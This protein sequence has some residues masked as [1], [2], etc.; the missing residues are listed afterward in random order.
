MKIIPC[1]NNCTNPMRCFRWTVIQIYK[2]DVK[3]LYLKLTVYP[4]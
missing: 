1:E 2:T 3:A 4:L